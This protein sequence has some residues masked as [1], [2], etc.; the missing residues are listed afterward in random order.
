MNSSTPD[1]LAQGFKLADW[2]VEPSSCLIERDG[3]TVHLE[4]KVMDLLVF[5]ASQPNQVH[6]RDELLEAVWS[7]VIV[8]DEALT[9]AIIKLRKAF[10]DSAKNPEFIETLPKRGYR[11]IAPLEIL[12]PG[13]PPEPTI[14][15]YDAPASQAESTRGRQHMVLAGIILL[16]LATFTLLWMNNSTTSPDSAMS[17]PG[18]RTTQQETSIVVLPFV[19]VGN[20][21]EHGY[22]SDGL[23]DDLI[24]DLS[25]LS[26]LLV[27]SRNS[28]FKYKGRSVDIAQV[29]S[30]LNVRYILQGSVRRSGERVR[31]NVELFDTLSGA[32]Q[33]S[34]RYDGTLKDVFALQD[35][36]TGTII[37]SLRLQ[38]SEQD[39][40]QLAAYE[41][42]SPEAYDEFLKGQ[43][44]SW[45]VNRDS[46]AE[47]E[48]HFKR[49]LEIDPS[50]TRANA[51]LAKLY[52]SAWTELWHENTGSTVAGWGRAREQMAAAMK[53]PSPLAF[54]I[55][56][57]MNLVNKRY[58]E[59]I[60]DAESAIRLDPNSAFGY[61]ALANA[62]GYA[63]LSNE[64]IE[65]T[66]KAL[67]LDP[68][69]PAPY[70]NVEG[71]VLYDQ[72]RYEDA[73]R[74]LNRAV[75]ANPRERNAMVVLIAAHGQLDRIDEAKAILAQLNENL[76]RDKLPKLTTTWLRNNWPYRQS[77]SKL[78]LYEGLQKAGVAEW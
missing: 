59:A 45:R 16:S 14:T 20:E 48:K 27:I 72:K 41:T 75:A 24:T 22:F 49:A 11:L 73:V 23:T 69:F 25:K 56:S 13:P 51:A 30:D 10:G 3:N 4:P 46:F 71:R 57:R 39:R 58:D 55:Q 19:N 68:N 36:I 18:I 12:N 63:G 53:K 2:S 60:S 44:L 32:Q 15:S 76:E 66:R 43:E 34:E 52:V 31:V 78:H 29:I 65:N 70:L 67:R 47:A 62:Q 77:E 21:L 54:S 6:S 1:I 37:S 38:L 61:L 64:A 17:Q 40:A 7:G 5:L 9:N 42:T 33:W 35:K 26:N 8:S 50:Y 74:T 28:A